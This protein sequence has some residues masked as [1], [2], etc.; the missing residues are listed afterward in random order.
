M[1]TEYSGAGDPARSIA[2][3]WGVSAARRRG[4]RP[5]LTVTGITRAAIALADESGLDAVTMRRVAERIGNTTAMSLYTYIPGKAEL[6][7]LML[8]AVHGEPVEPA[9]PSDGDWRARLAAVARQ[10]RARYLRHPWLLQVAV[11]RPVLGPH[12]IATY[13]REL[14]AVADTGLS[15]VEMDL[16]VTMV[17]DYVHGA[18]RGEIHA[19]SLARDSGVTDQQWWDAHAPLLA[20]VLDADRFPLASRVGAAAGA[21]YGAASDP[22]RAFEFGLARLLDGVAALV[23]SRRSRDVL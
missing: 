19:A 5:R 15:D 8:D 14:A 13:D 3:L 23:A 22:A 21:A 9:A 16:V 17:G 2:L 12:V 10:R 20:Q 7:D 11:N 18:V 1:P 6:L 4:P